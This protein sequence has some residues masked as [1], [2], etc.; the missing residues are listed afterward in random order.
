MCGWGPCRR[1]SAWRARTSPPAAPVCDL[2]VN[3]A[4]PLIFS[5]SLPPALACAAQASLR[6]LA[7]AEGDERRARL[8]SNIRRFAAGL[9][10]LGIPARE[11]SAIFPV[12]LGAP[13]RAVSVA[14]RL[15]ELGVLAKPIRPPTVPAGTSRIR[16]AVSA[17]AHRGAHQS[18][19]AAPRAC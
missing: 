16:F 9:R 12:V 11:D 18:R 5:T 13:E 14:A 15:R 2:L 7:G 10:E 6:I 1:R 3:R 8:W 19:S 17:G 4:R